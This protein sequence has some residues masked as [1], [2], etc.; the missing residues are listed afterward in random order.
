[1]RGLVSEQI[2]GL[3]Q[4]PEV[5]VS[6]DIGGHAKQAK[7]HRIKHSK[8]WDSMGLHRAYAPQSQ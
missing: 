3:Q 7:Q 6:V 4:R 8:L 2:D 1:M 5:Q